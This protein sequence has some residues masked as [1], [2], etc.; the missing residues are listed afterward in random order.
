M[1]EEENKI[2]LYT[3]DDGKSQVSLLSRDGRIWLNQKQMAELFAV[4]KLNISMLI[5]KIFAEKELDDSVVKSY[6]TTAA[7]GKRYNVSYRAENVEGLYV[8]CKVNPILTQRDLPYGR[9]NG[10]YCAGH[11]DLFETADG[12]WIV[13]KRVR[14]FCISSTVY[15]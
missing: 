7:D 1:A 2:I 12:E 3:T 5:A 14:P 13:A 6:S 8:P 15:A 10:V 4:S 9:E 11:A